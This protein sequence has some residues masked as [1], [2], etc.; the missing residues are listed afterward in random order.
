MRSDSSAP[1]NARLLQ[2]WNEVCRQVGIGEAVLLIG[3]RANTPMAVG[4]GRSAVV[5]PQRLID[6]LSEAELRDVLIH[7]AEHL[8]RLD[9]WWVLLQQVVAA[10][11]WPI[12]TVHFMNRRLRIAREELCDNR[13][14]CER[15]ATAYGE[16]LLR[17]ATMVEHTHST[18]VVGMTAEKGDLEQRIDDFFNPRRNVMAKTGM[19]TKIATAVVLVAAGLLIA[20]TR[21]AVSQVAT[22]QPEIPPTGPA[23]QPAI[24]LETP[25]TDDGPAP[26]PKIAPPKITWTEV[27]IVAA[28]DP[29][30]HRGIVYGGNGEPLAGVSI[31]AAST[32][33][34]FTLR[35]ADRVTTA[36]LGKVRGV[37]DELGRFEFR[38]PD[39]SWVDEAGVRKRWETLLVATADGLLPAWLK[40]WGPT[41][42]FALIGTHQAPSQSPFTWSIQR[43]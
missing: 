17:V 1:T 38:T 28:D 41:A 33:E 11:Y 42:A 37:T 13:V 40:T 43:S 3:R 6:E 12:A 26:Q 14:L 34:I 31:Y 20:T 23:P 39:L 18:L 27:P 2:L 25:P 19:S 15:D 24:P 8:R 35:K 30:L 32:I 22:P 4:L 10:A 9:H 16:T 29:T 7:E 5:V 21:P 36:D